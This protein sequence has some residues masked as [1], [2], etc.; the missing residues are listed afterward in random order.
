M[1]CIKPI[2]QFE[3]HRLLVKG[4]GLEMFAPGFASG[5]RAQVRNALGVAVLSYPT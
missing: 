5:P 4:I 1:N 2:G 3:K